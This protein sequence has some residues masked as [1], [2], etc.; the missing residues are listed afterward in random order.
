MCFVVIEICLQ[1]V[2]KARYIFSHAV[3]A[4]YV[5]ASTEESQKECTKQSKLMGS[6]G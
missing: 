5:G 4:H 3:L 6:H 1:H 2:H